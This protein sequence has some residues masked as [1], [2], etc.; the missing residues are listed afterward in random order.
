MWEFL[1]KAQ[2]IGASFAD[3]RFKKNRNLLLVSTEERDQVRS[4]G[5]DQGY[6][7]RVL[8]NKNWGYLSSPSLSTEDV[9]RAISS[10]FGD[11]RTNIVYL[12]SKKDTVELK[13]KNYV[14]RSVEEK[15]KVLKSLR[16]QVTSSMKVSNVSVSYNESWIENWYLSSEGRDIKVKYFMS[17]LSISAGAHEA[18]RRASAYVSKFSVTSSVLEEDLNSLVSTLK[19]RL[20]NQLKGVVP[21]GGE[22]TVVLAP[23]VVGVFSHEAVGHLAEADLATSGVLFKNRG[24]RIAPENV[25]VVDSPV[26]SLEGGIGY[27][28]YDDEGV[29]GRKVEII[30]GGIV[31]E[32]LTD[33]YYS[34]YLGQR[35]TGNARA[36]DYRSPVLIRM[37]NTFIEPGEMS[38]D[39]I[40][41]EVKEGYFLVSTLGGETSPEGTF[42]FGIQEGYRVENGELKEPLRNTGISGYTMETLSRI[43]RI[44]KNFEMWPGFCGKGGQSVPVGTG[45]PYVLVEKM[46]VG[47]NA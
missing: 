3:I 23:D 5:V 31:R 1:K 14:E 41:Q 20:E 7:L 9:K 36:E 16:E 32:M 2:E 22:H 10:S 40:L 19:R 29:E 33:R 35:P 13:P 43:R 37:R 4:N 11:E 27:V 24:K 25:N 18:D 28:P 6:S 12:P 8:Y 44:S 30:K 26:V 21:D 46:K 39:E 38:K 34:A 15:M 42:Q 17:G 45:G 47:G